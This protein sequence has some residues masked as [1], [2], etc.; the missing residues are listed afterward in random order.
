MTATLVYQVPGGDFGAYLL[1]PWKRTLECR[2]FG[3]SYEHQ[4]TSNSVVVI[5]HAVGVAAEPPT[6][7]LN[8]K[9][10]RSLEEEDLKLGFCMHFMQDPDITN[11]EW[12]FEE[13]KC[14]G[15]FLPSISV[16]TLNFRSY[17]RSTTVTY[18]VVDEDTMAVSIVEVESQRSSVQYGHML[19]LPVVDTS[20]NGFEA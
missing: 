12:R 3:K 2:E 20:K 6:Y 17:D 16:A 10:G 11:L 5:E 9:F 19:R 1:G 13:H 15:W 4:R 8:W 14:H 7:F 18:R